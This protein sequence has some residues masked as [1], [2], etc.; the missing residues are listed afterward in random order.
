[1]TKSISIAVCLRAVMA[2]NGSAQ[3]LVRGS[4]PAVILLNADD[5]PVELTDAQLVRGPLGAPETV[6]VTVRNRTLAPLAFQIESL[7][8][9]EKGT[10]RMQVFSSPVS[11][12]GRP[13]NGQVPGNGTVSEVMTVYHVEGNPN[14]HVVVAIT[15]A[16]AAGQQWSIDNEPLKAK[17]KEAVLSKG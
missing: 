16:T 17:A 10:L 5:A 9:N 7:L 12:P 4:D 8:F 13:P 15:K 6:R 11:S 14:W 2:V 3:A 1:M